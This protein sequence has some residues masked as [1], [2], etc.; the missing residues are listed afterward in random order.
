M[1]SFNSSPLGALGGGF[2]F[3]SETHCRLLSR[4]RPG[5]LCDQRVKSQITIFVS[6]TSKNDRRWTPGQRTLFIKD[7]QPSQSLHSLFAKRWLLKELFPRPNEKQKGEE[8]SEDLWMENV[9][10]MKDHGWSIIIHEAMCL[11]YCQPLGRGFDWK[12][13][14]SI[15]PAL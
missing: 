2:A 9:W 1:N 12:A 5:L 15:S 10:L 13:E 8:T 4:L 11:G 6:P 7:S 14:E 3:A